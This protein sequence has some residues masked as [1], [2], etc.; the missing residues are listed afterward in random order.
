LGKGERGRGKGE[1]HWGA[2]D[3]EEKGR[4]TKEERIIH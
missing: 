4:R 3:K 2:E 1:G